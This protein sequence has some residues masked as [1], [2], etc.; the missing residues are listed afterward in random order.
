MADLTDHF[1]RTA[2]AHIQAPCALI[3]TPPS[4]QDI[5]DA[6]LSKYD[7]RTVFPDDVLAEAEA[8]RALNVAD[9][10]RTDLRHLPFVTIDG[11]DARDHDDAM[12]QHPD[13]SPDNPGGHVIYVA[14]A[15]V[16]HFVPPG[17]AIDREAAERGFSH[18]LADR[19]VPMLPPV[20]SSDICSLL[21]D[22]DRLVV[23][24][25]L[26]IDAQGM[27]FEPVKVE[28]AVIRS[29]ARLTYEQLDQWFAGQPAG[30]PETLAWPLTDMMNAYDAL[31]DA[32]IAREELCLN[33]PKVLP[34]LNEQGTHIDRFAYVRGSV[35]RDVVEKYMVA[36]NAACGELLAN[37]PS[38]DAL[39]R[40]HEGVID[41]KVDAFNDVVDRFDPDPQGDWDSE[42]L[43][44]LLR[45]APDDES[46]ERLEDGILNLISR[47][48]YSERPQ[49]HFGLARE[50]YMRITSP[51][52]SFPD[53][54]DQRALLEAAGVVLAGTYATGAAPE[55]L[56]RQMNALEGR[57]EAVH[58]LLEK[59]YALAWLAAQT[60]TDVSVKILQDKGD[61]ITL[62]FENCPHRQVET[63]S[64]RHFNDLRAWLDRTPPERRVPLL[65]P[66]RGLSHD[67]THV[68]LATE[69]LRSVPARPGLSQN[70]I[71]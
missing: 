38:S 66:V 16:A 54:Y 68:S 71:P 13:R 29:H 28:R 58:A 2:P 35:S 55:V 25:T 67:G 17:G 42:S 63:S 33:V 46:R 40:L 14:I 15:D 5:N 6:V 70:R 48:R 18:Y 3:K 19:S 47:S 59:S 30:V 44:N 34:R 41:S 27:P 45:Y 21:P 11:E 61:R 8:A 39:F 20:L 26:R 9:A 56:A 31:N 23:L 36:V 53:L 12:Y 32:A 57:T 51:I 37:N 24:K 50:A 43:N 62:G 52:R 22:Q 10:S 69:V 4:V 65:L 7:V 60:G 49:P 1:T 64:S